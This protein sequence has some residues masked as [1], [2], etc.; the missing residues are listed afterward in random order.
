[1]IWILLI[2][3]AVSNLLFLAAA[4]EARHRAEELTWWLTDAYR[5]LNAR[6][7]DWDDLAS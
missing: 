3:L 6:D 1:M 4:Y 5:R 7:D 2:M